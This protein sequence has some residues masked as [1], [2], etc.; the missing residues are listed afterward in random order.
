MISLTSTG[1]PASGPRVA[2]SAAFSA[3][4]ASRW[5]MAFNCSASAARCS[6]CSTS[7]T[8]LSSPARTAAA[9]L[10]S[11]VTNPSDHLYRGA[12]ARSTGLVGGADACV[13]LQPV[14]GS[15]G[16][17]CVVLRHLEYTVPVLAHVDRL[18]MRVVL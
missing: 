13:G 3:P 17:L 6:A 12:A 11:E 8:G 2:C 1:I 10:S 18:E 9:V 5:T 7:A 4:S 14:D 16:E 15:V